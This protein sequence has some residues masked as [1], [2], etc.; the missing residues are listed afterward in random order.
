MNPNVNKAEER[1]RNIAYQFFKNKFK[2]LIWKPLSDNEYIDIQ[3]TG[4]TA[5]KM[6]IEVKVRNIDYTQFDSVW[7]ELFKYNNL[8]RYSDNKIKLYFN[9]FPKNNA[10]IL[11]TLNQMDA[12]VFENV[13]SEIMSKTTC[14]NDKKGDKVKK[15]VI[16]LPTVGK[17]VSIYSFYI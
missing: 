4:D 12:E 3:A 5:Y 10:I 13:N 1:G 2:S 7:L 17:G 15:D 8:M 6:D 9:Y 11:Y 16:P 14:V